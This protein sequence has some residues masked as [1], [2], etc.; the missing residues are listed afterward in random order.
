MLVCNP[1]L[2]G[3]SLE[4]LK[5]V[6]FDCDGVLFD[7][8]DVN[9][10]FYNKIRGF[11]YLPPM[12]PEQEEFVHTHSVQDSFRHIL[13]PGYE[14]EFP[15]IRKQLDYSRL[16][17]YMKMEDGLVELM[18]FLLEKGLKAAINTNRTDTMH[19][20][21]TTYGLEKYFQPVV[22]AADVSRPKPHPESL[23]KI[24]D[25]WSVMPGEVVFIGDSMVDQEAAMGAGTPFWAF[26]NEGLQ[27][28]M[29]I[30]D[31]WTLK[32]F[33]KRNLS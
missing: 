9:I 3:L 4:N 13:P 29:L 27:A 17:T 10:Q 16:L 33:L 26:K 22:T 20:L 8:R 5:G 11:F 24:L 25:H 15:R 28:Q 18:D 14:K 23:F 30:P 21:L 19:L 2:K 12:S 32:D 7:S 6:I 1:L 31:F